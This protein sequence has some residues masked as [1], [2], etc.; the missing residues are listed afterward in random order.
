[1]V[2]YL[3]IKIDVLS[4]CGGEG[5]EM[6]LFAEYLKPYKTF[7]AFALTV[8]G[9]CLAAGFAARRLAGIDPGTVLRG[10]K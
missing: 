2:K 6:K 3:R 5:G 7:I 8:A 4:P 10:E 1:V 9:G